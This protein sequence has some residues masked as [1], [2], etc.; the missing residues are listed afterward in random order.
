MPFIRFLGLTV[1][2]LQLGE[3]VDNERLS[4]HSL[5]GFTAV[6]GR[7]IVGSK[8]DKDIMKRPEKILSRSINQDSRC[9]LATRFPPLNFL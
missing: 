6:R 4:T 5:A 1:L 3:N 9:R 8:D 7:D 2:P